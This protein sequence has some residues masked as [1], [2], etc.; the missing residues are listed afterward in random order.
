MEKICGY[1]VVK[2]ARWNFLDDY[3]IPPQAAGI[4]YHGVERLNWIDV[5][6]PPYSESPYN[7]VLPT[8]YDKLLRSLYCTSVMEL[9]DELE[10]A[11]DVLRF[12]NEQE[13]SSEIIVIYSREIEQRHGSFYVDLRINW[14][15][16]DM[17]CGSSML[18]EGIFTKPALFSDFTKHLNQYGLFDINSPIVDSYIAHYNRLNREGHNMEIFHRGD[19]DMVLERVWIGMPEL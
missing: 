10:V 13:P 19:I 8:H 18:L 15:G 5:Y 16:E 11:Q 7:G 14:L 4:Y 3:S 2:R 9:T 12:V 1:A 17:V 6:T